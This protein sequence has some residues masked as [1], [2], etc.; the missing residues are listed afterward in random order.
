MFNKKIV[1]ELRAA[2]EILYNEN[3]ELKKENSFLK[4]E[5]KRLK[6]ENKDYERQL[7]TKG[8]ISTKI[9]ISSPDAEEYI[10]SL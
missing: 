3:C 9:K 2:N 10:R 5:N 8:L 1:A 7:K 6:Q 4:T